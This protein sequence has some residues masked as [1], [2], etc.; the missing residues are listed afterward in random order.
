MVKQATCLTQ[1]TLIGHLHRSKTEKINQSLT[2]LSP[3]FERQNGTTNRTTRAVTTGDT[4]YCCHKGISRRCSAT[5]G[6]L[7]LARNLEVRTKLEID[8]GSA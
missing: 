3:K 1:L 7:I 8:R 5:V 4:L 2:H 6:A